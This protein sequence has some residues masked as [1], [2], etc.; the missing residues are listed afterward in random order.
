[1]VARKRC[2]SLQEIMER[3]PRE[4]A[5]KAIMV[6]NAASGEELIAPGVTD[7]IALL[8]AAIRMS[9]KHNLVHNALARIEIMH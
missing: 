5:Q 9:T 8:V 7:R 2:K 4:E 1:M 3:R 6:L